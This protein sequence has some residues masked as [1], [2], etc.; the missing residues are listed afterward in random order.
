MVGNAVWKEGDRTTG[1][2]KKRNDD[3]VRIYVL[4]SIRA[5]C[6]YRVN[7]WPFVFSCLANLNV[8]VRT[9]VRTMSLTL[10]MKAKNL[11]HRASGST[12][13]FKIS[14]KSYG[15]T[16]NV[17]CAKRSK[18]VTLVGPRS[19]W[20]RSEAK[21]TLRTQKASNARTDQDLSSGPSNIWPL[22]NFLSKKSKF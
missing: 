21:I 10:S 18:C 15:E 5:I 1:T 2:H 8:S 9:W 13:S 11:N 14:E 17:L 6:Y 7:D 20:Y 16:T 3:L 12:N 22:S 19:Y 4:H